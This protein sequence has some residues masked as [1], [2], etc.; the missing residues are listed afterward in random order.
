MWIF[1]WCR[2]YKFD[3]VGNQF[4]QIDF[5]K[6]KTEADGEYLV[7]FGRWPLTHTC[8]L[9]QL[10]FYNGDDILYS[11]K[12]IGVLIGHAK[13]TGVAAPVFFCSILEKVG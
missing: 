10:H 7:S 1:L 12:M 9:V 3:A 13:K 6:E 4:L 8:I 5:E 11:G 2:D